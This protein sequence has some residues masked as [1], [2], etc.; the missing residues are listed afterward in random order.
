MQTAVGLQCEAGAA[1]LQVIHL[2]VDW[3]R[4]GFRKFQGTAHA[5]SLRIA[6]NANP[7]GPRLEVLGFAA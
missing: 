7:L 5:W 3:P 6:I 4:M 2:E 1:E